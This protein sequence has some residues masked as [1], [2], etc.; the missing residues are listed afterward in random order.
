[1]DSLELAKALIAHG[2][3]VNA[4]V[5]KDPRDGC[6]NWMNRIGAT[7]FIL[8]AKAADPA[9][10]H[11]LLEH[12]ANPTLDSKDHTAL[13]ATAGIGFWQAE[14]PGSEGDALEAVKLTLE[15][16]SNVNAANDEGFTALHGAAVRGANSIVQLLVEEPNWT[17]KRRRKAGPFSDRRRRVYCGRVQGS[18]AHC[19]S[20]TQTHGRY[21]IERSFDATAVTGLLFHHRVQ[22]SQNRIQFLVVVRLNHRGVAP[23]AA[24]V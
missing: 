23:V 11:L 16:E 10:M 6:R 22:E 4:R 18:A 21:G 17:Q 9:F 19:R 13:M 24:F 5:I 8:A 3:D 2:A 20:V 12:G 14:S 15:L 1:M 7:P